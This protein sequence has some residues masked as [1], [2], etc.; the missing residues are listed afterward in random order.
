MERWDN[1]GGMSQKKKKERDI[2]VIEDNQRP[3]T[4]VLNLYLKKQSTNNFNW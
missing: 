3:S 4:A 2:H 1:K